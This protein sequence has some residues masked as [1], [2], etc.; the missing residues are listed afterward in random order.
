MNQLTLDVGTQFVTG[1]FVED[2]IELAL[3]EGLVLESNVGG[4]VFGA[5]LDVSG[6]VADGRTDAA[7][8]AAVVF[9]PRSG[10]WLSFKRALTRGSGLWSDVIFRYGAL[11]AL[12]WRWVRLGARWRG[13]PPVALRRWRRPP[14]QQ[15]SPPWRGWRNRVA[16]L[17][18]GS[19]N[20]RILRSPLGE[21]GRDL[22][23]TL[24]QAF[25]FF[26]LWLLLLLPVLAEILRDC[27]GRVNDQRGLLGLG[28]G[29]GGPD[30]WGRS[31]AF[32]LNLFVVLFLVVVTLRLPGLDLLVLVDEVAGGVGAVVSAHPL[33]DD[34][35]SVAGLVNLLVEE[36][37]VWLG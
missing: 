5:A 29:V 8:N 18:W 17:L 33:L 3:H 24:F 37:L 26:L 2:A 12:W 23:L 20:P 27:A 6:D 30:R 7:E 4:D 13:S 35:D 16:S 32:L 19:R 22:A 28:P 36:G 9:G 1:S 15:W 10:P 34:V 14:L 11:V 25:F 21:L 31:F